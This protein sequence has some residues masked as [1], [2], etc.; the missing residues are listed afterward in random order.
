MSRKYREPNPH[1]APRDAEPPLAACVPRLLL[2]RH[3]TSVPPACDGPE[4]YERPLN[5]LGMQQVKAVTE[6][7]LAH[8]PDRVVSSPYR[9][10]VQ[11]V[12]PTADA[13]GRRVETHDALREWNA[14]IGAT[15][16]WQRHHR[17]CWERPDWSVE[18]GESHVALEQRA[19]AAL[20]QL[21]AEMPAA[22]VT[23]VGS[24]GA[25]IARA[26]HGLGCAVD[27]E[28]WLG[29][30][31]PAIFE[32]DLDGRQAQVNDLGVVP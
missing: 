17:E 19:V 30:P 3:A 5:P 31:M 20:R 29:M 1:T 27:V 12:T 23:I 11:T 21:V 14:G 15:P 25:W 9:R 22:S 16:D 10:S 2:V 8:S 18:G 28:F 32:V 24:H 26:L 13:L 4:E 7:L 6:V